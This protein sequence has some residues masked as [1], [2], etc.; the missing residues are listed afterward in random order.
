MGSL[1]SALV[2][3]YVSD[4][5]R[6]VRRAWHRL[7]RG[8][9]RVFT[10]VHQ[11]DDPYGLLLLQVVERLAEHADA[12]LHVLILPTPSEALM[13]DHARLAAW[14][15]RDGASLAQ[16][17]GLEF[18]PDARIPSDAALA[19]AQRQ[20]LALGPGRVAEL[21]AITTA[22]LRGELD[23]RARP[24][25]V[26]PQLAANEA[27]VHRLGHY[28]GGMLHYEGEWYWGLDRLPLLER[29]L[30]D[31]GL[32]LASTLAA[33]APRVED[34]R[35]WGASVPA[36][37]QASVLELF[38]SLRSP[39]SY[40]ALDR[41]LALAERHRVPLRVR[42]V[43]PMVMRGL[44]VPW[45]KRRYI[46]LDAKR[47]AAQLGLAFGRIADPVGVGV[48]RCMAVAMLAR[49][50]GRLPEF[51]RSVGSA[52]WAEGLDVTSDRTLAHVAARAGLEPDQALTRARSD[53]SW[54]DE[55][56][57]NRSELLAMGLWG[58]PC[59]R[60]GALSLW[61]QDRLEV[62][63]AALAWQRG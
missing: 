4:V 32:D 16:L 13:P 22:L 59:F 62:L 23:G 31:E 42:L 46:V 57:H 41:T 17:H 9:R 49:E 15:L 5:H 30:R 40:L 55:V 19:Q 18:P 28:Q 58:V 26:H 12:Q 61:G 7:A 21:R 11:L 10:C 56:E 25:P 36:P 45:L 53:A 6:D 29:R 2:G 3:L 48:E 44:A 33:A 60:F 47:I 54:R 34:G 50:R 43:L 8:R 14:G 52:V 51:L 1:R 38:Y 37:G 27:L 63:A 39:Y 24:G 20:A 35:L